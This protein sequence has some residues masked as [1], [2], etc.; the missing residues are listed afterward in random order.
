MIIDK[1]SFRM[2]IGHRDLLTMLISLFILS[3]CEN[4]TGIGLDVDPEDQIE[5]LF[6]DTVSLRAYT[7]RD[8]SV[9]SASFSQNLFGLLRDPIFGKTNVGLAIDIG[10]P[11]GFKQILPD[12]E[13]DSIVL[14]LPYGGDYYGDTLAS[15]FALRVRPLEEVFRANTYSTYQWDVQDDVIGTATLGRYAY[16]TGVRSDSLRVDRYIDGRDTTIWVRP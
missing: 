9:Q 8:D 4:P 16:K 13:I 11:S 3:G 14:V 15:D 7:V 6:T 1:F 12:A 10:R 2:R 5:A